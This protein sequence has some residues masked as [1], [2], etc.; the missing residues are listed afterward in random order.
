[1]KVRLIVCCSRADVRPAASS[2]QASGRLQD[3]RNEN[4]RT[5]DVRGRAGLLLE[6]E[7]QA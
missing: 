2:R 3:G 4:E 5:K 1:M 6:V 7:A